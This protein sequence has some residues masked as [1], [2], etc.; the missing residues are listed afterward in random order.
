MTGADAPPAAAARSRR[1]GADLISAVYAAVLTEVAETGV[2]GLTMEGI[3]RRAA[4]GK[5]TLYRR[6]SSPTELLLDAMLDAHPVERPTP[7]ATDLRGDLI[8]ALRQ[9]VAWIVSPAGTAAT[10]ILAER[11]SHPA[12]AEALYSRVFDVRGGTFTSTVL[13]H[14]AD[15]GQ[16]DPALLTPV[17]VDIGEALTLKRFLDDGAPPDEQTLA[18]I[19]DQAILPAVGYPPPA[20]T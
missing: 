20:S 14:Y 11:H 5:T 17:V 8:E 16:F 18:A 19:V 13:R 1:R 15:R 9:L 10:R 2:T 3:A 4:T 7:G 12:L 6:W